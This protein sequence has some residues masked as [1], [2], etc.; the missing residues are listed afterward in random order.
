MKPVR[1]RSATRPA[2]LVLAGAAL[3]GGCGGATVTA[4]LSTVGGPQVVA[5]GF[6]FE[7]P[8]L[9][10]TADE[11]F[12]LE[13]VNRDNAPHN[14]SI[15]RDGSASDKL[16]GGDIFSGPAS[17]LY[18]IPALPAGTWFF[19]CDVHPA[20]HG[21]IVARIPVGSTSP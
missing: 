6:A 21:T 15:Y 11:P 2:A 20:M 18:S 5:S 4:I 14:L 13:L 19:R 16:F 7:Q 9:E 10:V 17:R 12:G 8:T 1:A 3:L